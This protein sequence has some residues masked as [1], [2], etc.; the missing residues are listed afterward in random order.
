MLPR[1]CLRTFHVVFCVPGGLTNGHLMRVR[2]IVES[3]RHRRPV[4]TQLQVTAL[5]RTA[6]GEALRNIGVTCM[7]YTSIS[8][9]VSDWLEL[10]S[11]D[12]IVWD[13]AP[14]LFPETLPYLQKSACRS[15]VIL[16]CQRSEYI[17]VLDEFLRI[18]DEVW[19]P[20]QRGQEG[21]EPYDPPLEADIARKAVFL[22]DVMGRYRLKSRAEARRILGLSLSSDY[23]LFALGMDAQADWHLQ[24]FSRYLAR[25]DLQRQ[26]KFVPVVVWSGNPIPG[27]V[28]LT[29]RFPLSPLLP[30]FNAAVVA[31]GYNLVREVIHAG[32]P[33]IFYPLGRTRD[34]C[35]RRFDFLSSHGFGSCMDIVDPKPVVDELE[36]L[37]GSGDQYP[38]EPRLHAVGADVAANRLWSLL[39]KSLT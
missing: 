24:R 5:L 10:Q 37:C 23:V 7:Q 13:T 1:N 18:A 19:L 34:E 21:F 33:S 31:T 27:F 36:R 35:R 16:R 6:H 8:A 39:T 12:M 9:T 28:T 25:A 30:A 17:E 38:L 15:V 26:A 32:V 3:A 4:G 29:P 22:G 14:D 20:H 11:V 2:A